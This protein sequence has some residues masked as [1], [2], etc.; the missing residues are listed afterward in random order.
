MTVNLCEW[1]CLVIFVFFT[2]VRIT[3]CKPFRIAVVH[4][5]VLAYCCLLYARVRVRAHQFLDFNFP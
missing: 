1:T 2:E 4:V 5:V 3:R